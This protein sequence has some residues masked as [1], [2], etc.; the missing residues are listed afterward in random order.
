MYGM[1]C[2]TATD[3]FAH[4][5]YV[6]EGNTYKPMV[7]GD[8]EYGTKP[9]TRSYHPNR[10]TCAGDTTWEVLLEAYYG[11]EGDITDFS[12]CGETY[13]NDFYLCNIMKHVSAANDYLS[14]SDINYYY[15]DINITCTPGT[16]IS[17]AVGYMR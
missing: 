17:I 15:K 14:S 16:Y 11:Y 6:K 3:V 10:F 4:A 7:H 2:H 13:W 1:A 12:S 8:E 5:A 9:D